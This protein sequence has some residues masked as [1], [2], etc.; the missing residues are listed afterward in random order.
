MREEKEDI[1]C[2]KIGKMND[3]APFSEI[4]PVDPKCG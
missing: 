1:P 4:G 3:L 2:K